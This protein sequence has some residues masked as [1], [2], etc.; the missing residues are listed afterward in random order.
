MSRKEK[1]PFILKWEE[2]QENSAQKEAMKK[3]TNDVNKE[4][5]LKE[6]RTLKR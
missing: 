3:L 1:T 4:H 2:K 6:V 5:N